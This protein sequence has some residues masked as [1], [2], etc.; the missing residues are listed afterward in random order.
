MG[1]MSAMP[2]FG[3]IEFDIDPSTA[4][5]FD[6]WMESGGPARRLGP[7]AEIAAMRELTLVERLKD[8]RPK[9][10][11]QMD[12]ERERA[13]RLAVERSATEA[14]EAARLVAERDEAER[15]AEQLRLEVETVERQAEQLR[16]ERMEAEREAQRLEQ[17]RAAVEAMEKERAHV[18]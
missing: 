12:E 10:L 4:R 7:G 3:T 15:E 11:R 16:L 14:L 2:V 6:G 5:W 17:Q 1:Y 18:E 13:E 8:P 9:F